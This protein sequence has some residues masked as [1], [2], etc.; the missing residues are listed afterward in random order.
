[1]FWL[2]ESR[3]VGAFVEELHTA[4]FHIMLN[5]HNLAVRRD[6]VIRYALWPQGRLFEMDSISIF[7]AR[8]LAP[9]L[10]DEFELLLI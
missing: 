3:K 7:N 5:R 6:K 9:A 8:L 1:V 4:T 2:F 10:R